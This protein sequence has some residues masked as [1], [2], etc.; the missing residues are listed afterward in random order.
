M[1]SLALRRCHPFEF[2]DTECY[3]FLFLNEKFYFPTELWDLR[4]LFTPIFF[5][6]S[7]ID[8]FEAMS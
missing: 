2:T 7:R 1:L 8:L 5:S 4:L 3:I 6:F